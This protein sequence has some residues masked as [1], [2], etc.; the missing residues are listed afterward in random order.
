MGPK[1]P[2]R[3]AAP[4]IDQALGKDVL[5][6][7]AKSIGTASAFNF[8]E[9]ETVLD[10][11]KAVKGSGICKN[12]KL[13]TCLLEL[14]PVGMFRYLAL[15]ALFTFVISN[16]PD[17]LPHLPVSSAVAKDIAVLKHARHCADK[18]M[19]LLAHVRRLKTN[20]TRWRQCVKTLTRQK[21]RS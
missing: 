11:N 2:V 15:V 9:Y 8:D 20:A 16:L 5:Q 1:K 14:C 17:V 13:I 12:E 21:S 7:Y 6:T 19:I 3:I 10:A 18:V 4:D